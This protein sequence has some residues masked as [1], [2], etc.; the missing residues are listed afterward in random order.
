MSREIGETTKS[1][2]YGKGRVTEFGKCL[3]TG[4]M[5]KS[6]VME[7][8]VSRGATNN[9]YAHSVFHVNIL[10][11]L[12]TFCVSCKHRMFPKIACEHFVFLKFHVN[13]CLK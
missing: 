5:T 7:K 10:C 3:E 1:L 4:E 2:E 12:C 11:F 6:L 13:I 8:G 9:R